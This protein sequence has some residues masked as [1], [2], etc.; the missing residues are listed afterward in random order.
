MAPEQA[1]GKN[2][3]VGPAADVYALGAVLYECLTGRPPFKATTTLET[4]QQVLTEEP[5]AVRQ[6]QPGVP[7]DLETICH[8]CLQKETDKRYAT[9]L[10]LADDLRRFQGGE[11]IQARPV[12]SWERAGK[13]VR[14][15]PALAALLG[16]SAL[17]ALALVAVGVGLWYNGRLKA[18]LHEADAQRQRAVQ[19]EAQVQRLRYVSHVNLAHRFW[20][21]GQVGRMHGLLEDLRPKGPDQEDLRGFEWY[22]LWG[23]PQRSRLTLTP[24]GRTAR[25]S[26]DGLR[27]A[28][29]SADGP[30]RVWDAAT[31]R[32]LLTLPRAGGDSLAFSHDGQRLTSPAREN[33]KV[34][35]TTTGRQM[36]SL[37]GHTDSVLCVAFSPDG[38]RLASASADRT[39]KVWDARSGR[40]VLAFRKHQWPV[41]CV[42]FSPDSRVLAS[43]AWGPSWIF[44]ETRVWTAD[45]GNEI[46]DFSAGAA[47]NFPCSLAFSPDGKQLAGGGGDAV[48]IYDAV[49][50]GHAKGRTTSLSGGHAQGVTGVAFSRDGRRLAS[51]SLDGTVKI[52]DVLADKELLTLKG[53]LA[54]V[55]CVDFSPDGRYVV[56]AS[57][58]GTARVWDVWTAQGIPP[59]P[60]LPAPQQ[61]VAFSPDGKRLAVF[62]HAS[63]DIRLWDLPT[64]TKGQQPGGRETSALRAAWPQVESLTFSPDGRRLAAAGSRRPQ[65]AGVDGAVGIQIWDLG[66]DHRPLSFPGHSSG[67]RALAFSPDGRRLAG[68][69]GRLDEPFVHEVKVWDTTTGREVL[70]L[71][72][73]RAMIGGVAFSPGGGRLA[74]ASWD[75]VVKLSDA[76][77]GREVFTVNRSTVPCA[78]VAFSPDEKVLAGGFSDGTVLLWDADTGAQVGALQGHTGLVRWLAFSPGG[79]NPRAL[80][81]RLA[82]GSEDRTVKV[83]DP[84]TG[85]E[86]LTLTGHGRGVMRVAF[87]PDG[88]RLFSATDEAE[89]RIWDPDYRREVVRPDPGL[90]P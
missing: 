86:V 32:V 79:D 33:V 26:P 53:H 7:A 18:A 63:P 57:E 36:L 48:W 28:T 74:S 1:G 55:T 19:Q 66:T 39:V 5:A 88:R 54:A 20:Q 35:D 58:D 78:S 80:G 84:V 44:P 52:W 90:V 34:W 46:A 31:G 75:G 21:E 4:L 30:I 37:E 89:V 82:T 72:G 85:Q 65:G 27:L 2:K 51:A 67:I 8:K 60:N 12:S 50:P 29:T 17:A 77:T 70:S 6:V 61:D 73:H 25:F 41:R 15:R 68:G 71:G 45:T 13:W 59:F 69:G 43:S 56:S 47:G 16:V 64:S 14:R 42:V 11:P 23:L 3:E 76:R 81:N 87:S 62:S 83:W 38:T 49:L 24:A 40:E 10:A 22:Y 9:A